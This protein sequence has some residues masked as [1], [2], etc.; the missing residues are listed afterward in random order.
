MGYDDTY[1]GREII[2]LIKE[3]PEADYVGEFLVGYILGYGRYKNQE[4]IVMRLK[5]REYKLKEKK[6]NK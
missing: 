5:H 4:K 3:A 2:E 6:D 1:T